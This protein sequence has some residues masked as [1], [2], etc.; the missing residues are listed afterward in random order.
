MTTIELD[1]A[2]EEYEICETYVALAEFKEGDVVTVD[3]STGVIV[4][5]MESNF[6]FP[7]GEDEEEEV[8]ASS[9]NPVYV[10]ATAN[11]AL[12]VS[13]D[14]LSSG[15]FD[16]DVDP[17]ELANDGEMAGIYR[18]MENPHNLAEL[19]NIKGVDDPEVGF[20]TLPKGWT[21]KS[22]L[23]AWASLGGTFTSCRARMAGEV[24]SPTRFC[25]AL[26]D[27]VLQTEMWRNKF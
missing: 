26:K 10:V 11:G 23:Q 18:E 8:E 21:R 25:A 15:S 2:L 19:L 12:A 9:D 5:L 7:T 13:E 22:V 27:E 4:S 6:K 17:K 24:R 20:S 14:E 1:K 16:E 3:G